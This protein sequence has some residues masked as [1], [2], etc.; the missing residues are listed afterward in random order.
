MVIAFKELTSHVLKFKRLT[1]KE[2]RLMRERL[3]ESEKT[4]VS[5]NITSTM[6]LNSQTLEQRRAINRENAQKFRER[7]VASSTGTTNKSPLKV[8]L[9][10]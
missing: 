9:D 1:E 2:R 8:K 6:M 7:K 5:R 10:F 3:F 4:V